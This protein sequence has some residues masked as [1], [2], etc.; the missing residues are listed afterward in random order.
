LAGV[1]VVIGLVQLAKRTWP[2]LPGQYWPGVV[3]VTS[4]GFNVGLALLLGTE[5]GLASLVGLVT[6]LSASG[7]YSYATVGK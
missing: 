2:T 6:G 5:P 1:P 7:L 4:V 3:L